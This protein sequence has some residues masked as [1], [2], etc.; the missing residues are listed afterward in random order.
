SMLPTNDWRMADIFTT[1]IH[2]HASR[3]RLSINQTN[4][5]AWS[6][7]L[8]GVVSTAVT[9]DNGNA[10]PVGVPVQPEGV[11]PGVR[12]MVTRIND[13]RGTNQFTRLS[14]ILS[15]RAFT[16]DFLT[17]LGGWYPGFD[18]MNPGIPP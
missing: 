5:A 12:D 18:P 1:E 14:D 3:G 11:L 16:T 17:N 4:A 10:A 7:L 13:L 8:A 6:A 9:N 15:V 2:P